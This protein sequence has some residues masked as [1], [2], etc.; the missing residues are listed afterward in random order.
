[1]VRAPITVLWCFDN[2]EKVKKQAAEVCKITHADPRCVAS[3][4]G[5]A[6]T[7]A[8]LIQG[9]ENIEK[10]INNVE[11]E[12]SHFHPDIPKYFNKIK[13]KSLNVFVLRN[14]SNYG[15]TLKTFGA[16]LWCL[17]NASSFNQAINLLFLESDNSTDLSVVGAL[18]GA[19]FGIQG[20]PNIHLERSSGMYDNWAISN[21]LV[22]KYRNVTWLNKQA[23]NLYELNL[24]LNTDYV[25]LTPKND[26]V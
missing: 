18:L 14:Y 19:R 16:A 24:K 2:I 9:E 8:Y 17:K 22:S 4:I 13:A 7:V 25:D 10:I 12:I 6:M 20:L 3:C 1:L 21:Q 11:Q 5:I 26:L 23:V 15:Y